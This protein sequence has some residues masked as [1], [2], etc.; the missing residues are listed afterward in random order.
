MWLVQ[1]TYCTCTAPVN[2]KSQTPFILE[3]SSTRTSSMS[4]APAAAAPTTAWKIHVAPK[5]GKASL[6][7]VLRRWA[8]TSGQCHQLCTGNAVAVEIGTWGRQDAINLVRWAMDE[9]SNE[10]EHPVTIVPKNNVQVGEAGVLL[11]ATLKNFEG[12]PLPQCCCTTA[13]KPLEK[14]TVLLVAK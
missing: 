4:G 5:Q 14:A 3:L 2:K 11:L 1:K 6:K 7:S 9:V 10:C 12:K 13:G 8:H